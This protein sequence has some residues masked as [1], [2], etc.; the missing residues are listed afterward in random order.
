[1]TSKLGLEGDQVTDRCGTERLAWWAGVSSGNLATCPNSELRRR[2]IGSSTGPRPVRAE[3]WMNGPTGLAD[4]R[5]CLECTDNTRNKLVATC[6]E[7]FQVGN[8]SCSSS[9]TFANVET[10]GR[11]VIPQTLRT[12]QTSVNAYRHLM[13]IGQK[14]VY[15]Q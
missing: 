4:E 14:L 7:V 3:T 13:S 5:Y 10:S 15:H 8:H 2:T 6:T 12:F 11:L 9:K 1:M